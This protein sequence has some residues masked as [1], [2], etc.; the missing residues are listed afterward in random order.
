VVKEFIM[1]IPAP[2]FFMGLDAST[3]IAKIAR[4]HLTQFR[5]LKNQATVLTK[6]VFSKIDAILTVRKSKLFFTFKNIKD[7]A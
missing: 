1:E 4:R 5:K 2:M 7:N 6:I 3:I